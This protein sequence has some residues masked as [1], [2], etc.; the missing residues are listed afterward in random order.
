[1]CLHI[2]F[3]SVR[4]FKFF[5]V[6]RKGNDL[7]AGLIMVAMSFLMNSCTNVTPRLMDIGMINIEDDDGQKPS[8]PLSVRYFVLDNEKSELQITTGPAHNER[9]VYQ[10]DV[11]APSGL[12]IEPTLAG[13]AILVFYFGGMKFHD[14]YTFYLKNVTGVS[15]FNIE[16][17]NND[18]RVKW[19]FVRNLQPGS[20]KRV[21][22]EI[23]KYK[24]IDPDHIN[25]IL[26]HLKGKGTLL[27]DGI[28]KRD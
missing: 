16:V 5:I 17:K 6:E 18:K 2:I 19:Y 7:L 4:S 10:I 8:Q 21:T 1:M 20:W 15:D 25:E 22:I 12:S 14:Q 27:I 26:I 28:G 9:A 23:T 24:V 13:E 11:N 3:R